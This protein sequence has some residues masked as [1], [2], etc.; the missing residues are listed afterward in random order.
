MKFAS[1]ETL[2]L[3]PTGRSEAV[4]LFSVA[5]QTFV[6]AADSVQEIRSTDSLAGT[7]VELERSELPKVRHMV[8]RAHRIYYV[9][10]AGMHFGLPVTRPTLV[11]IL[12]QLRAAVLVDHIERM[13]EISAV[14]A[15]PRAFSGE[16]REWYRGL[17]YLEDRVMPVIRPRGFLTAEE[18]RK[19]DEVAKAAMA[20]HEMEGT[21]Q[22]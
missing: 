22:Q 8:E 18:F 14:H 9:V 2:R 17:A 1:Q 21:A 13:A 16:E 6:I 5:N 10:N 7:A 3:R 12:R 19:L 20:E 11:L 4:I 15:L